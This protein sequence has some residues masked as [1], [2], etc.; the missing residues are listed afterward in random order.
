MGVYHLSKQCAC[1]CIYIYMGGV[2]TYYNE[3]SGGGVL[4][5]AALGIQ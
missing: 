5:R 2:A 4:A 3:G 1:M